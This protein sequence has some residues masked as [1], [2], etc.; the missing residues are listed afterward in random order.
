[1]AK[2]CQ[3]SLLIA[4]T[5]LFSL[6]MSLSGGFIGAYLLKLGFSF[7]TAMLTYAGIWALRFVMRLS[8]MSLV[9]HIGYQGALVAGSVIT[10]LQLLAVVKAEQTAWLICWVALLSL[11]D[12][13]YWPVYHAAGAVT[14]REGA[15]GREMGL[16][17][18]IGAA[19]A[20]CGPLAGGWM[21]TTWGPMADFAVAALFTLGSIIPVLLMRRVPAGK[22]PSIGESL[23][24]IDLV[25]FAAFA[26][27]GWICAGLGIAWPMVLFTSLGSHYVAFGVSNGVAAL[28][29]AATGMLCGIGIDRGQRDR[30]LPLVVLALAA[31]ILMRAG[32]AWSAN[33][34]SIANLSGAAV[35]GLYG[36]VLMSMIYDRSRDS[37]AAYRFHLAAE[38]GWAVSGCLVAALIVAGGFTPSLAV[39]PA[40]LGVGLIYLCVRRA[41]VIPAA[42]LAG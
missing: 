18:V 25:S 30:F 37:G 21:L 2:H 22:V 13:L 16:R 4:H 35:G 34:A 31:G 26:A 39:A 27:D 36:P 1:M 19:V 24:G 23:R 7:S 41:A 38:A 42:A 20:L 33:L 29:G 9:R 8:V 32:A 6:A 17:Q 5:T 40:A 14:G 15:R 28:G 10:A 11:A 3:F 12:A